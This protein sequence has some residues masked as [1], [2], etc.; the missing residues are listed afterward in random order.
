VPRLFSAHPDADA[1]AAALPTQALGKSIHYFPQ[2]DSTNTRLI[3]LAKETG[4]PHGL[5][6][7]ADEQNAGRG[8]RG[9][10]WTAPPERS[11]L[12]SF[13]W[14]PEAGTLP[15]ARWGWLA[16]LS[17]LATAEAVTKV[18]G[19]SARVKWPNDVVVACS[20][21]PAWRKLGG[22]LCESVLTG[23]PGGQTI[24]GIGLNVLQARHELPELAKALPTS[25]FLE[26]GVKHSRL[27]LLAEILRLMETRLNSLT[28]D[29]SFARSRMELEISLKDWWQER[30][31]LVREASGDLR[32]R[33]TGLDAFG[34][35]GLLLPN[36]ETRHLADG[37]ILGLE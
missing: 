33:F 4:A 22:I 35:L 29:E 8:R 12:F 30:T 34:R 32:G 24:V 14:K 18:S 9:S 36:G 25:I 15:A 26:S 27:D 17:G 2:T 10:I 21:Q 28:S 23:G 7:L 16:L 19:L 11:L 5:L 6:V 13:L 37:E 31:L 1:Y 3:E 20:G